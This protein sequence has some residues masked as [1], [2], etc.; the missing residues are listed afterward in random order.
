MIVII[1][2]LITITNRNGFSSN[3]CGRNNK[4]EFA[5]QKISR[6]QASVEIVHTVLGN[7][8]GNDCNEPKSDQWNLW[9]HLLTDTR[10][11][12]WQKRSITTTVS[13]S[14]R[15]Y[16][17]GATAKIRE[18]NR[19]ENSRPK[20]DLPASCSCFSFRSLAPLVSH[21]RFVSSENRGRGWR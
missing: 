3:K 6:N 21:P 20:L 7:K 13:S 10:T 9:R 2:W 11:D 12:V 8:V 5:R 17:S 18:Q 1:F 19:E 14:R 16:T 15:R 4:N